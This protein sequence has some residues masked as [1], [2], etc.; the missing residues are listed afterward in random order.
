MMQE[1]IGYLRV[2]AQKT[3]GKSQAK[4][5]DIQETCEEY[6]EEGSLTS[7]TRPS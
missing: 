7:V 5:S 4:F 1:A 3:L 2:T 6:K